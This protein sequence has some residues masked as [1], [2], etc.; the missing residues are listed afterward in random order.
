V[1]E[2]ADS[3][4]EVA[5]WRRNMVL[6]IE[7]KV[8]AHHAF[9]QRRAA[10][11][12]KKR[13]AIAATTATATP[14][15]PVAAEPKDAAAETAGQRLFELEDD[16]HGHMNEIDTVL[17]NRPE[18]L[19]QSRIVA[20]NLVVLGGY[21]KFL[22]NAIARRNLALKQLE[23]YRNGLGKA[24]H[25]AM[26]RIIAAEAAKAPPLLVSGPVPPPAPAPDAEPTP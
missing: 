7:D 14:A 16:L 21:E 22:N 24:H 5:R 18:D 23:G 26:E 25:L 9:Q 2:M 8:R 10:E 13:E 20:N 1:K 12:A 11:L 15:A 4:V 6:L 17:K 3:T 19:I